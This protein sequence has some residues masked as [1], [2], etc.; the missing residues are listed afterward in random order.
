MEREKP[1]CG[2][3]GSNRIGELAIGLAVLG[4]CA[5]VVCYL[6]GG[7]CPPPDPAP[8][9]TVTKETLDGKSNR[10]I[11]QLLVDYRVD[12][13]E[14][15]NC[16]S[17]RRCRVLRLD[18]VRAMIGMTLLMPRD[19]GWWAFRRMIPVYVEVA[20][21]GKVPWYRFVSDLRCMWHALRGVCGKA[22]FGLFLSRLWNHWEKDFLERYSRYGVTDE[23]S[24]ADYLERKWKEEE[25]NTP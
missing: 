25:R 15:V 22:T 4:G 10:E 14:F 8:T 23:R 20:K 24:L 5:M 21:R 11:V 13:K 7:C 19:K 1:C 2:A 17:E 9:L 3:Q 16:L 6:V 18:L 12:P